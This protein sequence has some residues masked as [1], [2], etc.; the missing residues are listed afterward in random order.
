M[1]FI[2]KLYEDFWIAVRDGVQYD[3]QI[4]LIVNEFDKVVEMHP[5]R[6]YDDVTLIYNCTDVKRILLEILNSPLIDEMLK[7]FPE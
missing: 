4:W 1:F 7:S 6:A 5:A 2:A 3:P